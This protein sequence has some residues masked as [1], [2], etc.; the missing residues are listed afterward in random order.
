[1]A[2]RLLFR[3]KSHFH[4]SFYYLFSSFVDKPTF[5]P[6]AKA[7]LSMHEVAGSKKFFASA[8]LLGFGYIKKNL[9]PNRILL[10]TPKL[11]NFADFYIRRC[12][13]YFL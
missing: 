4:V 7:M 2:W 10:I 5:G 12:F 6:V 13:L 3:L 9:I 11:H 8:P 1:M